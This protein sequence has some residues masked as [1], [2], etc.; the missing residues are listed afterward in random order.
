MGA[1]TPDFHRYGRVQIRSE[2]VAEGVGEANFSLATIVRFGQNTAM[3]NTATPEATMPAFQP[4]VNVQFSVFLDMRVG[5]M[6]E[7]IDIFQDQHLTLAGL[8][9]MD[10][11]DH[12][13]VRIV[14]SNHE[15]CRRLLARHN[16]PA[17]EIDVVIAE[18]P[19]ADSLSHVCNTLL[20]AELNLHY[21]YPLLVC[22]RGHTAIA[23]HTDDNVLATQ[24]LRRKL[25]TVLAENDLGENATGSDPNAGGGNPGPTSGNQN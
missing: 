16:L 24:L 19:T 25:I 5:K 14:T 20:R 18:L 3:V 6:L 1:V 2:S 23:L 22:P 8:S 17:S 12:A 4:P 15:L 21:L 9:V 13:V 11:T 7:L 10:A